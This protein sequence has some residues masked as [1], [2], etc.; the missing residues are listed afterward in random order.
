MANSSYSISAPFRARPS[1]RTS[2]RR[3][4]AMA[5]RGAT[6]FSGHP[7]EHLAAA[8]RIAWAE[9]NADPVVLECRRIIAETRAR[10]RANAACTAPALSAGLRAAASRRRARLGSLSLSGW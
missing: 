5:R 9:L 8:L 3:A 10:K 4:W 1:A 7:R 2:M 6:I